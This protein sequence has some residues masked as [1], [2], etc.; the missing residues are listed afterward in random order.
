MSLNAEKAFD[1]IEWPYLFD[2]MKRMN[3][4]PTYCKLVKMLYRRPMAQIQTNNDIY[5][6]FLLSRSTRQGCVLSPLLFALAIEPLAVA[7]RSHPSIKAKQIGGV[8]HKILLY[9]DDVLLY[10]T[11]PGLS[12]PALLETLTEYSTISGYKINLTKSVIMPL[13]LAG[14]IYQDTIYLFN[15]TLRN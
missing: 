6:K 9:A 4:G 3:I 13:N 10:L 1:R 12:I 5:S 15:G 11:D 8:T 2:V 14:R 7:I